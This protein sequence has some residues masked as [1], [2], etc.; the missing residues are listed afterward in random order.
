MA[1]VP[2]LRVGKIIAVE[3]STFYVV[4]SVFLS[5]CPSFSYEE[6]DLIGIKSIALT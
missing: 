6:P 5:L 2:S 3:L 1:S 4:L